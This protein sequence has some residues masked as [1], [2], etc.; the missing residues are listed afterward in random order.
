MKNFNEN[1]KNFWE[2]EQTRY[3]ARIEDEKELL[4]KENNEWTTKTDE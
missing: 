1:I 2:D 4:E 3:E